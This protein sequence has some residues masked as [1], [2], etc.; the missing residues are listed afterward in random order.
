M[1][2]QTNIVGWGGGG[3]SYIMQVFKKNF[4]WCINSVVDKNLDKHCQ[5]GLKNNNGSINFTDYNKFKNINTFYVY[6]CP[7]KSIASHYNRSW[8]RLQKHKMTG[9]K[10]QIPEDLLEYENLV[11]SE[12]RDPFMLYHH[13]VGWTYSPN[14]YPIMLEDLIEYKKEFSDHFQVNISKFDNFRINKR[15]SKMSRNVEYNKFYEKIFEKIRTDA[16]TKLLGKI[17]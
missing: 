3:Q 6:S 1:K 17:K 15:K 9:V 8:P 13:Y 10:E 12:N 16:L 2:N 7:V 5:F 4:G 11:V 14:F